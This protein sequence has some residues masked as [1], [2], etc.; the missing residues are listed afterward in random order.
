MY[1][2]AKNVI[3]VWILYFH[4][5]LLSVSHLYFLFFT[6]Q[7]LLEENSNIRL[8]YVLGQMISVAVNVIVLN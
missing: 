7:S 1:C 5:C 2:I 3:H 8:V 4:F 6:I